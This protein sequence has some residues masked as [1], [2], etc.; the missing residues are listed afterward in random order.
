[1]V[2]PHLDAIAV[3]YLQVVLVAGIYTVS[4]FCGLD[5]AVCHLRLA[6]MLPE[7]LALI[8][9]DVYAVHVCACILTFCP[10]FLRPSGE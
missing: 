4:A 9:R 10:V 1:M 7:Y 6:H 2:R 5:V 3:A 8:V